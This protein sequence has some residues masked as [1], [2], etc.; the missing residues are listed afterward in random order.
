MHFWLEIIVFWLPN[1]MDP[2]LESGV[3]F[4]VLTYVG[5]SLY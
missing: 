3:V 4:S 2:L 5:E 1:S